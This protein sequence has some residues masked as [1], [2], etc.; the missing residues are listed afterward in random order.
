M[1]QILII[2]LG[3]AIGAALRH[4]TGKIAVQ[5]FGQPS[6]YTGTLFSNVIGCFV[7]GGFLAFFTH[8]DSFIINTQLFLII[9]ILGSY[10]TFSSFALESHQ[11]F[12]ISNKDLFAYLFYQIIGAFGALA[13]GYGIVFWLMEGFIHV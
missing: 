10:T 13:A 11:L 6:I 9:G 3:G 5:T 4:L 2:A 1:T 8:A 12:N 7:G